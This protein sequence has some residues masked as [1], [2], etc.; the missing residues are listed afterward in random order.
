MLNP[1][2][3][4]HPIL[5]FLSALERFNYVKHTIN[6]YKTSEKRSLRRRH[7]GL[8]T[9]AR[10]N[11]IVERVAVFLVLDYKD[12]IKMSNLP[13]EQ[14]QTVNFANYFLDFFDRQA[15]VPKFFVHN[16]LQ[17]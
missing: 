12:L 8:K 5:R 16:I 17:S 13:F 3:R 9:S 2:R 15:Y 4:C 10:L 6:A 14:F 11:E 1:R 7:C